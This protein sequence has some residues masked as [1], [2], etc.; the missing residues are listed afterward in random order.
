MNGKKASPTLDNAR[1][2]YQGNAGD[3]NAAVYEAR[4]AHKAKWKLEHSCLEFL[5]TGVRGRVLDVPVGTG[6]FLELY[7]KLGLAAVG[8]DYSSEMLAC[9]KA[10]HPD[11][12]LEQGDA[13]NL[14]FADGEFDAVICVRLL[15]LVAPSEAPLIM[16]ELFRVSGHHVMVT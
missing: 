15:H 11:A 9:A 3:G 2:Y 13:T 7:R 1:R 10:A 14:R 12:A 4:R 5:L 6:R 8:V 16:N